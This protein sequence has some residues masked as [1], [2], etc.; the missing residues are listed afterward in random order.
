M[1]CRHIS[2]R[3]KENKFGELYVTDRIYSP[4]QVGELLDALP[5]VSL[6][7]KKGTAWYNYPCA[8]DI[9]TTSFYDQG[10]KRACMYVWQFCIDGLVM[11]G[12][13]WEEWETVMQ[14]LTEG[15]QLSLEQRLRVYVH[16]LSFEFGFMGYRWTWEK[17]FAVDALKPVYAV[18]PCGI[19]FYCSY[20][21]SGYSLSKLGD[22]LLKYPV[23]KLDG[24]LDY[25][26][27]RH[28][29]TPLT[30]KE[31]GYCVND[32]KVVS[33]YI[34]ERIEEEHGIARIPLTKTGY[35][36]RYCRRLC[37]GKGSR[38]QYQRIM[39]RL[40]LSVDEYMQLRRAFAG[41]FTHADPFAVGN[42]F[43]EVTSI[44]FTSSYPYV[45]LSEQFPMN[46]AE[47]LKRVNRRTFYYS[48]KYYC[49]VFDVELV[50][51][52]PKIIQDSYLSLSK[53]RNVKGAEIDNGRIVRADKL[54]TTLTNVDWEILEQAYTWDKFR[55]YNFRRY[56]KGYLPTSFV[57]AIIK[58]YGDK[59]TLKGV[60]GKEQEYLLSKG[61][62]NSCYGMTVTAI[63]RPEYIFPDNWNDPKLPDLQA[64]LMDYNND[65][66]RFLFYPWGVFVT[67]Y[68]RRNLWTGIL[69]FGRDYL[70]SDTDSIKAT[71]FE[72][73]REYVEQYNETCRRKL[74]QAMEYHGIP[75]EETEPQTIKGVKK[76]LGVWD[77]E[78]TYS[79][80]KTMGAKR[81]MVQHGDGSIDI[82]VAGLNKK[83][84]VPYLLK[85]GKTPAGAFKL[86]DFSLDVPP[87]YTGKNTHTY[88]DEMQGVLT[89]YTGQA[90]EYHEL[91][92]VHLEN[93][94][95]T[96][97]ASE[98]LLAFLFTIR[99][100]A[101]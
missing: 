34:Q 72:K 41:G 62:L 25:S 32:V 71:N 74:E 6:S 12:R 42:V 98:D 5:P 97:N 88:L 99:T 73:H 1:D 65:R 81:Y 49:C 15:L 47:Y 40:T 67:A 36:R 31:I 63:S 94:P 90:G 96:M 16:N 101:V 56:Q 52:R 20:L 45:M 2:P 10:E 53:C 14:A 33:A 48:L 85:K 22:E 70:Y 26:L 92:G 44:D 30:E 89:D 21:L 37:L 4:D 75:I 11:M 38:P 100:D 77:I 3:E 58:L 55:V 59:T 29:G 79:R 50:G 84:A 82:T 28:S 19:E 57:Q 76:P 23:R 78:E 60:D 87:E 24:D 9:E 8:F 83:T 80:F 95:Y 86:F 27:L 54:E 61:M 69:A 91:S 7:R 51:L 46:K 66:N 18:L 43:E 13:T 17:V 93:A 39:E 35:V 68:A 64:D